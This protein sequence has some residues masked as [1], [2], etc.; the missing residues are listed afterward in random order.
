MLSP[1]LTAHWNGRSM[2]LRHGAVCE[3]IF[4]KRG[5]WPLCYKGKWPP[6]NQEAGFI[7]SCFCSPS[8]TLVP[9]VPANRFV[10]AQCILASR[11]QG[12][13]WL[14][15]ILGTDWCSRHSGKS[16]VVTRLDNWR[17][18]T[19]RGW[20]ELWGT[21]K[22]ERAQE[23]AKGNK[24]AKKGGRTC[25]ACILQYKYGILLITY[26]TITLITS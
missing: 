13:C 21:K 5:H 16:T 1:V 8:V 11:R 17:P 18:E 15:S 2:T 6:S 10:L 25:L 9:T 4:S 7:N 23:G 12:I 14:L 24:K 22:E 26:V 20:V 19:G 3:T